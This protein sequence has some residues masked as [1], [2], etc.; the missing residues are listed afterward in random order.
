MLPITGY[1]DRWS[2]RPGETINF[3]IG[4]RGGG[5]YRARIAR[6]ICGDPNPQG[7]G[8]REIPVP[9]ALEGE[10]DGKEQRIAKGSWI[11]IPQL[12]LGGGERP[13]AFAATIWPTLVAADRQAVLSWTSGDASLT[14]GFGAK[15]AFCRL[16]TPAG[17]VDIDTGV[18]L[19]ERAWHDIA[20]LFDPATG[21]PCTWRRRPARRDLTTT[22]APRPCDRQGAALSGAGAAAIAAERS[23]DGLIC[24]STARSNGHAS[25]TAST[26]STPCLQPSA[27]AR[28]HR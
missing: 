28:R 5:R 8:Y 13:I 16:T 2:V 14:L 26:L 15:G 17:V 27:R 1:V 18:S 23:G 21:T 10:H 7:P 25:S 11:D 19:T 9:W 22:S 3:M 24:T 4:V 6:V 20:C 12:D